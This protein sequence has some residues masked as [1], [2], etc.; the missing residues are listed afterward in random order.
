MYARALKAVFE[1]F[2]P[3]RRL[4]LT[5]VWMAMKKPTL[6]SSRFALVLRRH[7]MKLALLFP[8]SGPLAQMRLCQAQKDFVR[9]LIVSEKIDK[10]L[11][12]KPEYQ[13]I[14]LRFYSQLSEY[15]QLKDN[16]LELCRCNLRILHTPK[17]QADDAR[18]H[19]VPLLFTGIKAL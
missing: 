13:D 14:K 11:I 6:F 15:Y 9:T 5:E 7:Q 8:T 1:I 12:E 4:R 3:N 19:E 10:E 16:T 18:L 17:I 2:A